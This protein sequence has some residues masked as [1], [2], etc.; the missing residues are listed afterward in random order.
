MQS[1]Y[2]SKFETRFYIT[3][4]VEIQKKFTPKT[5]NKTCFNNQG[6]IFK[7]KNKST[8]FVYMCKVF[9]NENKEGK[10]TDFR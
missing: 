8:F 1:N 2:Q 7:I 6:I 5:E 9:K 4:G 10:Q 3:F